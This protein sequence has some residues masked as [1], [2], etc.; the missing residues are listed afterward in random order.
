MLK[1]TVPVTKGGN[2]TRIFLMNKPTIITRILPTNWEPKIAAIPKSAQ[3]AIKIG[4][5][6]KL[7][8]IITGNR[9]PTFPKIGKS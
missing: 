9:E 1:I 6:A 2:N 3:M 5:Y 4:T 8:P 7:A